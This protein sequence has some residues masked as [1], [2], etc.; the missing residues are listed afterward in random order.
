MIYLV[1]CT[2]LFVKSDLP[3]SCFRAYLDILI[4]FRD[5]E[6]QESFLFLST[7]KTEHDLA[8]HCILKKGCC[9]LMARC[10]NSWILLVDSPSF[11]FITALRLTFP[12]CPTFSS[13]WPLLPLKRPQILTNT[14]H[15]WYCFHNGVNLLYKVKHWKMLKSLRKINVRKI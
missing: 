8:R 9:F 4:F 5:K 2:C 10:D 15:L 1:G 13:T 7:S 14:N 11:R 12:S 6:T 3:Q